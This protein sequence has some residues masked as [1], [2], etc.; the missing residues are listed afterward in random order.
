MT[1]LVTGATGFTGGHL[2]RSLRRRGEQVRALVRPG[3]K[4]DAL[5]E[6][7]VEIVEARWREVD[8]EGVYLKSLGQTPTATTSEGAA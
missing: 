7:G 4:V 2:A 3:S 8:L 6:A 1:V 5:V